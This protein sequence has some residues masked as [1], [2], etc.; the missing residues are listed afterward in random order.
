[1]RVLHGPLRRLRNAMVGTVEWLV[2]RQLKLKGD[3]LPPG[4]FEDIARASISLVTE[5]FFERVESGDIKLK[6]DTEIVR[7]VAVTAGEDDGSSRQ[8]P[9][10]ELSNGEVIPA[11]IVSCGTG[12]HQRVPFLNQ[13][14]VMSQITDDK[15]NFLLHRFINPPG[16]DNLFFIGYNSSLFCPTSFEVA[17]LWVIAILEGT[18]ELPSVEEQRQRARAELD[19]MQDRTRGKHS[20]G[21]NV[22]PFSLHNIDDMLGDLNLDISRWSTLTQWLLPVNPSSYRFLAEKMLKKRLQVRK[23][24]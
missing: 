3:T 16:I 18:L 19:W 23:D 7:L 20:R 17:A 11:D 8:Q 12:F 24:L 6:R 15:G 1:M 13:E 5:S 9:S 14:R 10:V 4:R 22:V 21:T 2:T